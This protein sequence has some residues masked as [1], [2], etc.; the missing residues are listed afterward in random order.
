MQKKRYERLGARYG[1][2]V[3]V[4]VIFLTVVAA[5]LAALYFFTKR[6]GSRLTVLAIGDP[7][8]VWSVDTKSNTFIKITIPAD[9]QVDAVG[10]YGRYSLAAL[11]KLG[12][13]DKKNGTLV[14]GSL[15]EVLGISIPWY[16]DI[17]GGRLLPR[18]NMP[19]PLLIS[20]LGTMRSVK[21]DRTTAIAITPKTAL[22]VQELPDA[23][24]IMV[25]DP[26]R[27]DALLGTQFEDEAIRREHL[28]VTVY[29]TTDM[30]TLGAR[31]GR[32]L[33][34]VGVFVVRVGNDRP[35][36]D[37]CMVSGEPKA[38]KS[39]TSRTIAAIFQCALVEKP[40][41]TGDLDVRVGTRYQARFLP[42]K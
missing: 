31:V 39:V 17:S 11:W 8:V 18:S 13:I 30:P 16:V 32:M 35:A 10:G 19:L 41:E 26:A 25:M 5:V 20:W 1:T 2:W 36:I 3:V 27:V 34:R 4:A 42:A 12:T 38:V 6:D 14:S 37:R 33:N 21:P 22:E 24:R 28:S 40:S 23:T 7:M 15:E 29:N 9:V